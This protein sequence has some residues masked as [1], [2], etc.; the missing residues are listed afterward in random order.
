MQNAIQMISA[1]PLWIFVFVEQES[2]NDVYKIA[3]WNVL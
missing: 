1:N 3:R 2:D